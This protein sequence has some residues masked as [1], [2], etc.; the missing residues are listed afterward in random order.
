MAFAARKMV[1]ETV[2]VENHSVVCEGSRGLRTC[3]GRGAVGG[4][5]GAWRL[6]GRCK[7]LWGRAGGG[8]VLG[9]W[10]RGAGRR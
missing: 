10:R 7:Y 1:R 2:E 9:G 8:G 4:R 5:L 6:A 3:R